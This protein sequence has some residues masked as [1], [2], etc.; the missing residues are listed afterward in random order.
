LF[1]LIRL[2]PGWLGFNA[3]VPDFTFSVLLLAVIILP[4]GLL[5]GLGFSWGTRFFL[6]DHNADVPRLANRA[7]LVE[8]FGFF[9]ASLAFNFWLVSFNAFALTLLSLIFSLFIGSLFIITNQ[10][11]IF[12]TAWLVLSLTVIGLGFYFLALSPAYEI[13]TANW[14]FPQETLI[15]SRNST[16]GNIAVTQRQ[17]QFNFYEQGWLVS[18]ARDFA[19]SEE[20]VHLPLLSQEAPKKILIIGNGLS[21]AL[22]E[23]L[24]YEQAAIYYAEP[25]PEFLP[26]VYDY[27]N[28]Q[29]QKQLTSD[30]VNLINQDAIAYLKNSQE[31]FDFILLNL[32]QPTTYQINRFY[33]KQFFQLL[34]QRLTRDGVTAFSLPYHQENLANLFT[35]QYLT[36]I[37]QPFNETLKNNLLVAGQ[38]LIFIGLKNDN[39]TYQASLAAEK[40]KDR[41]LA[42]N[43]LSAE[44][45]KYALTNERA[46]KLLQNFKNTRTSSNA[47]LQ[48][49]A[50]IR[51]IINNTEIA[52][53][54][55]SRL[56]NWILNFRWLL[57]AV[58]AILPLPLLYFVKKSSGQR[59]ETKIKL[60]ALGASSLSLVWEII[61][62]FIWQFTLGHIY[63]EISLIIALVML[64]IFLAN[65]QL[66][67]KPVNKTRALKIYLLLSLILAMAL[68]I[69]IAKADSLSQNFIKIILWLLAF[70]AGFLSGAIYPLAN[71][72]YLEKK[73]VPQ[74]ETGRIYG[75][76]LI[77]G[78]VILIIFSLF[79][80]PCCGL[81]MLTVYLIYWL[82]LLNF[83]IA[84]PRL[85]LPH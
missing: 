64:G 35:N 79:L 65:L 67:L 38:K 30:R 69:F 54:L 36:A 73:S 39:F 75:L 10:N 1:L 66:Y 5:L 68:F 13:K 8:T 52:Q 7:Y 33:T 26:T 34:N 9:I 63:K 25:D 50:V 47:D 22:L 15:A 55:L 16:W 60:I 48:P 72:L 49:I 70:I 24:K 19:A 71:A 83:L 84:I 59:P 37:Y 31:K 12:K 3:E 62:I 43:F 74:D 81:A 85:P 23:T 20:L 42:T 80:L 2:L 6:N 57:F 18:L 21:G 28:A 78:A 27:L 82:G 46:K 40:F 45:V 53:P 77:G 32:G 17:N 14:R 44:Y 4:L 61:V 76:E 56:L 41:N 11:K 29:T 58:L 51:Q